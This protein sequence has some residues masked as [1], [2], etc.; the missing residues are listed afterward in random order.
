MAIGRP[1]RGSNQF[2]RRTAA[3]RT[4][5][6][7][8]MLTWLVTIAVLLGLTSALP[9]VWV[10]TQCGPQGRVPSPASISPSVDD[11]RFVP[12]I[13]ALPHKRAL[14]GSFLAYPQWYIVH[15]YEEF[16]AM[17]ARED[18]AA[19]DYVGSVTGYWSN[20]CGLT[21]FTAALGETSTESRAARYVSGVSFSLEM[22]VKGA[23]EET[24]GRL[25]ARW[26]GRE[27]TAEDRFALATAS[28]QARFLRE[29]PWHDYPFFDALRRFWAETPTSG[30]SRVRKVE[31]RIA[32]SG[33]LATK[34][35]YA[36]GVGW[37]ARLSPAEQRV[38]SVVRGLRPA[39]RSIEGLTVVETLP[40]GRTLIETPRYRG[41]TEI[42][43]TL[44]ARGRELT[45]IAG[46]ERVL[47]TVLLPEGKFADSPGAVQV[48]AYPLQA[49]PGWRRVGLDA[50]IPALAA[51]LRRVVA[52]GG[53]F[54]HLYEP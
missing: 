38:R 52:A 28:D 3:P 40:D 33:E 18:E 9:V 22:I 29:R 10:E 19:F 1:R 6:F 50:T 2:G 27:K 30:G 17:L 34:G 49:R 35:V 21:G 44:L 31:R 41:Y 5:F 4:S 7:G 23:Y 43:R 36:W 8:R 53:E 45:E 32:L 14:A 16:A 20:L 54:E 15:A 24:I 26:R 46:N 39:D 11:A 12:I 47:V 13:T 25:S 37:L 51:T 42:V 48:F